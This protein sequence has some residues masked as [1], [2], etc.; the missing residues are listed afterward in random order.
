MGKTNKNR[1]K[2]NVV[3]DL[4][5]LSKDNEISSDVK[6]IPFDLKK[7]MPNK[8]GPKPSKKQN[9]TFS[10][11]NQM[12][13]KKENVHEKEKELKDNMDKDD[14]QKKENKVT[15]GTKSGKQSSNKQ[16]YSAFQMKLNETKN[17][18]KDP[19]TSIGFVREKK[20]MKLDSTSKV[21]KLDDELVKTD[22]TPTGKKHKT[23]ASEKKKRKTSSSKLENLDEPP[24]KVPFS[25]CPIPIKETHASES[26]KDLEI[27]T[28]P[29]RGKKV[30]RKNAE[31]PEAMK[32]GTE[33]ADIDRSQS[34]ALASSD[35]SLTNAEDGCDS[36]TLSGKKRKGVQGKAVSETTPKKRKSQVNIEAVDDE[37]KVQ[38][39]ETQVPEE[40]NNVQ[41]SLFDL[42]TSSSSEL[43]R[44]IAVS[45]PDDSVI[46]VLCHPSEVTVKGRVRVQCLVGAADVMAFSLKP[47]NK[48]VDIY[49]PTCNSLITIATRIGEN[50]VAC[51]LSDIQKVCKTK[52]NQLKN[53]LEEKQTFVVLLFQK[54]DTY[55][56]K[57]ISSF[58]PYASIFKLSGDRSAL[59]KMLLPLE[60]L[61]PYDNG[62]YPTVQVP[63]ELALVLKGWEEDLNSEACP[64]IAVCG[65]KNSGKSTTNR[66]LINTAL[67]VCESVYYLECD[68]GQTE[69]T[70]SGVV[71]LV[72]VQSP[73]AGPPF[74]HQT[75]PVC[76]YYYGGLSPKDNPDQYLCYLAMCMEKYRE[77]P[78]ALV[79]N[80]MG[81]MKGLGW[82]LLLDTVR[83][84]SPNRIVQ[85]TSH[86]KYD[87]VDLLTAASL[88]ETS[89]SQLSQLYEGPK[90]PHKETRRPIF[91]CI[92]QPLFESYDFKLIAAD[93]R[94]LSILSHLGKD[95]DCGMTL[96]SFYPYEVSWNDMCVHVCNLD[97]PRSQIMYALNA[98]LIALCEADATEGERHV[99]GGPVF[100]PPNAVC[101]WVGFGIVRGID[102]MKKMFYITTSVSVEKLSAVNAIVKGAVTL[103]EHLLTKQKGVKLAYAD[104]VVSSTGIH[105]KK[106]RK[107]L[108]RQ[109]FTSPKS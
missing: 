5:M 37:T 82:Q 25:P 43:K 80:T 53:S 76:A 31:T 62:E 109:G 91:F 10:S 94:N 60:V 2:K 14:T 65:G 19:K 61:L 28:K 30:K 23:S 13:F 70:P 51:A 106:R 45:G 84:T 58:Q 41:H 16:T 24:E 67:N 68:V 49:S 85:L 88:T 64:V 22:I 12:Q 71:S 38:E 104:E 69:F 7:I 95:I 101:K 103:P 15:K 1:N 108:T 57:F 18:E 63:E 50:N 90:I 74:C 54:I 17:A 20:K 3:K 26:E 27:Y 44:P 55:M 107:R 11:A 29:V 73:V 42:S 89:W 102:P 83:L 98:S 6:D 34:G 59:N 93:Y 47:G 52:E 81:W 4:P 40:I 99:E 79:V 92:E 8:T 97:V 56:C 72:R 48:A 75:E 36:I 87:N 86:N 96:N 33:Y 78:G 46:L 77:R 9:S 39:T 105:C 35:K 100:L 32:S 21:A 66:L